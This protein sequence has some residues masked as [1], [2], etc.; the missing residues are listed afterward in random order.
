MSSSE[1]ASCTG[2]EPSLL[3]AGI[4][5]D[6]DARAGDLLDDDAG[7]ERVGAGAAVLLG[8]VRGGEVG[9]AA[10]RRTPPPRG[11]R[12]LVDLGGVAGRPWRRTR[13]GRPR[14][15]PGA[16]RRARTAGSRSCAAECLRDRRGPD[17][18][19]RRGVTLWLE[20]GPA[21]GW[22]PRPIRFLLDDTETWAVV[23]LSGNPTA[24]PTASRS[25]CSGAASGSCRSTRTRRRCS[26]SR[27]TRPWPTCRSRSTSSTCSGAP[28]PPASSPTRRSRSAPRA[29]G[30]SSASSTTTRSRAPR[31]AGVPMVMDT[32]PAIEWDRRR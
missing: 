3:T 13:R 6:A 1:P 17:R 4:R 30:S 7:R 15:S 9:R 27:A 11:T 12:L 2:S 21:P 14:G 16:P 26:A 29:C 5:E 25:C 18:R 8:D 22:T 31:A 19:L 10:A 32:C 28:R 20:H 23:G 24:P